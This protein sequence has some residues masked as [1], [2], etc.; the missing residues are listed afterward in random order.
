MVEW[1]GVSLTIKEEGSFAAVLYLVRGIHM[2]PGV[3]FLTPKAAVV[4]EGAKQ[5]SCASFS[6]KQ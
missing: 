6:N 3:F 1:N 2:L 4:W 5:F